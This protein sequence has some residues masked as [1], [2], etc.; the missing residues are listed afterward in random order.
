[1]KKLFQGIVVALLA[2]SFNMG[3]LATA[4]KGSAE[5]ATALVKKAAAYM[6]TNGKEKAFA[7][8]NNPSGQFKDRDLYIT[9]LDMNGKVL[10]HGANAKL[11]DK[12]L[13][14]LKDVDGKYFVKGFVEVAGGKGKGWVDYKWPNP[15]TKAVEPKSSYVEKVDDMIF[16]GGI[17]K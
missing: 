6:K 4:D 13:I 8:I 5:E 15:I 12:N 17:Y 1:M 2:L 16:M 3:A 14:E 9:V 7:E 11:I 10:A